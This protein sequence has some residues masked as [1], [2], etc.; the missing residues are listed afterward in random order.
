MD[1]SGISLPLP[2]VPNIIT[3]NQ[4]ISQDLIN[5]LDK[6][7]ANDQ[8]FLVL[9]FT[10]TLSQIILARLP[11]RRAKEVFVYDLEHN[12]D[13]IIPANMFMTYQGETPDVVASETVY[14]FQQI[15]GQNFSANE[16]SLLKLGILTLYDIFHQNIG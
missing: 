3:A 6:R 16:A 13:Q 8:G 7:V 5:H 15:Y 1:L 14:I 2:I 4:A 12:P 10:G 11:K 9:D